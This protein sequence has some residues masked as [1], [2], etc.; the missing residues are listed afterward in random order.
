MKITAENR[1]KLIAAGVLGGLALIL[2]ARAF[3]SFGGADSSTAAVSAPAPASVV[4]PGAKAGAR[5]KST[6]RR[7]RAAPRSL[8]PELRYDWLKASED[9]KYEGVGRN[10]FKAQAEIPK[11]EGK[12]VTDEAKAD[13]GPPQPPPPPPINLKFFGFASKPGE[14]KKV[15]LSQGEDVFIAREGEIVDRRYKVVQIS[16]MSV[17]IEDEMNNHRQSIP[18]TQG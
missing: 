1:N 14:P 12:G 11:P 8:D 15:F 10:I 4:T 9:T 17:E 16:P 3:F 7:G 2:M 5:G 18:L 13:E 6:S